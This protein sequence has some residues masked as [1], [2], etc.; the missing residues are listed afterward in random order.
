[1]KYLLAA[2]LL[3]TLSGNAT[4]APDNGPPVGSNGKPDEIVEYKSVDGVKLNLHVF[5]PAG[6]EI[7]EK[8]PAIVFFF[9]G[10]WNGGKMSQFYSRS[11]YLASRGMVAICADYRV[12]SRHKTSPRECVKDGK[13]AIRWVRANAEQLGVDPEKIVASGGSAGGHV[14]AATALTQ[15]FNEADE[16][17]SISCRPNALVLYNPVFDNSSAGY[18]YER[19]KDYWREI[20]PMHNISAGAPP[21]LVLLG[22]RDKLIPVATAQEYQ[23]KMKA[24][25]E[26]CDLKL[27]KGEKHGFFNK[28]KLHETT[29]ELDSFLTSLGYL[30]EEPTYAVSTAAEPIDREARMRWWHE[31]KFGM[32]VHWGVYSVPGGEYKGQKLPNSAEWMMNRGKIPIAEYEKYAAQFNPTG[33]DAAKFVGLA[34]RAGM[35]YLVITAK[36]HDGFS[37]FGSKSSPY[38]VVD[39]TPFGRDVMK[40]LS[41]ECQKQGLRFG[42]YYSQAQDWHHPGGMGNNWDKSIK[43]VSTDEY[44]REK[45]APEVRQLLTEYG[46]IGIFW[47]D[48]PRKMSKESFDA[49]HSLTKLQP[50]VITNDRLGEDYPGDHKTFERHIPEQAPAGKAWEVCMPIS[51]SWGYKLG[52]DKFKS[53]ETL[54][55]N[56]IDIASKGGNYLLNVSPTGEGTLLP[57][58]VERLETV[59]AWMDVNGESIYGTQASPIGQLDW[60]RCTAKIAENQTKLYLHVFEWPAGGKL[61]V[62][63]LRN[64]VTGARLLDGDKPVEYESSESGLELSVPSTAPDDYAS[65]IVLEV[66]G[67][68]E[69]ER[70][71]PMPDQKGKLELTADLA[72]LH[73]NEGSANTRIREH[74]GVPHV[75]YWTDAEA[76]VEWNVNIDEPGEYAVR[77]ILSVADGATRFQIGTPGNTV[78]AEV[79]ATGGYDN[80]AEHELGVLTISE[81]GQTSILVKP[82]AEEWHPM[83]L[84]RVELQRQ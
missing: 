52:D 70:Q 60:G 66:E 38:N 13:S 17:T 84:R 10:G 21:T 64:K 46:P 61:S 78:V 47:W 80:Y 6:H 69:V 34:K 36:H 31:A 8:R 67:M 29:A 44:V 75:G 77:A 35:K 14:A 58:A 65:V 81:A 51:G 41:E 37:M 45:A 56:L 5:K 74:K 54:I 15:G 32:F 71:L 23:Q 73:N 27:Y 4:A 43:R 19:V 26:R 7:N 49:L 20:S 24:A 16:D 63:G 39:A 2:I 55:R 1:M 59:G 82:V 53:S 68:L 11:E 30:Q 25:G 79:P 62:P 12:K 18:G 28:S 76:W 3:A 50:G 42:F 22:T 48:T 9:G 33:F 72:F 40:E 83:N 57:Q